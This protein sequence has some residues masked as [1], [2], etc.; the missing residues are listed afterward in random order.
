MRTGDSSVFALLTKFVIYL[1]SVCISLVGTWLNDFNVKQRS[2]MIFPEVYEGDFIQDIPYDEYLDFDAEI[3]Q[4]MVYDIRDYGAVPDDD[5]ILNHG[6]I[7]A[8]IQAC[9]QNGGGTV[10]V[11]GGSYRTGSIAM[12]SNV[13]LKI[14]KDSALVASRNRVD[15]NLGCVIYAN[16]CDNIKIT[17]PG[18]VCGEGNY[19]SLKPLKKPLLTPLDYSDTVIM[20]YEYMSRV[21]FPHA[22]KYGGISSIYNSTNVTVENV[23]FENSAHWTLKFDN[24]SGVKVDRFIINNNRHIANADG[25]DVLYSSNV[26]I[27]RS[28]I[29]TAD[30]GIVLK[31]W[32]ANGIVENVT[33]HDCEVISCTNAFKIGTETRGII[34]N[35]LVENCK[36]Y[37]PDLYPGTVSGIAIES[38]DGTKLTNVTVRKIAMDHVTCP[39]FIRLGNRNR[40]ADDTSDF[41]GTIQGVT[42]ENI[43]ADNIEL[44]VLITGVR[45]PQKGTN[46][47]KDI[48]LKNFS[49]TYTTA[50]KEAPLYLPLTPEFEKEYPECWR[51]YNLP[52]YGI[53]ARHVDGLTA[54]NFSVEPPENTNRREF[55]FR[56]VKT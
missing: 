52:A 24:C 27:G 20:R 46:Y 8:A 38:M 55:V 12:K 22:S 29:S 9:T 49:L 34:R 54:E 53:W 11:S 42:I 7:N 45:N 19:Y 23:V 47:V 40:Y 3:S 6:A 21:R 28:F 48:T 1:L 30:D 25:I 32:S 18:K 10:L 17:G 35:I 15:M 2:N 14:A 44:P 43:K 4:G 33:V 56:D 16:G 39:L 51:F 26:D 36:F 5:A 31:N 50:S 13:T 41:S 37:M